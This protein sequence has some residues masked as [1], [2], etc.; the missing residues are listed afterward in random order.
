MKFRYLLLGV[1]A[2]PLAALRAAW[3]GASGAFSSEVQSRFRAIEVDVAPL[4]E[5][6]NADGADRVARELPPLLEK[7][8]A[9]HLAP[10]DKAAPILRA[11]INFVTLGTAGSAG[12][13]HSIMAIDF[14]EGAGE[15]I[16]R[17][18]R[19]IATYPLTSNLTAPEPFNDIGGEA[20][21][22]R[23]SNLESSFAHWLPGKMGL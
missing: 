21:R 4:R 6:G 9:A 14:I 10:G 20:N 16:G 19:V 1:A 11:R 22:L 3:L 18:G 13:P 5:G 17:G 2:S 12:G 15:V 8:F 7:A 23:F